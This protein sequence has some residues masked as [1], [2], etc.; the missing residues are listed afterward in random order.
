VHAAPRAIKLNDEAR[1][2]EALVNIG[3][4]NYFVPGQSVLRYDGK[5]WGPARIIALRLS[6]RNSIDYKVQS[7]DFDGWTEAE[8]VK[9]L[10]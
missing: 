4:E 9:R 5:S 8:N 3:R 1:L 10:A 2:L 6:K 7:Q